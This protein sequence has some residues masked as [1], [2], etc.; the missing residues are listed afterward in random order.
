MLFH[1]RLQSATEA[2]RRALFC[3]PIIGRA[4]R[5]DIERS[6]YLR[7]LHE[8]YHHVRH[9]VPLLEACR[10][11]L[12]ERLRWMRPA[13]DAYV[14]EEA[15]HDE[16]ILADIAA[17]GGDPEATRGGR[18]G[19]ATELMV[20]YAYDTVTRGNPLGFLGMVHVL[21]GTSAALA[22]QAADVIQA[23]LGLADRA[24]V[25]LRS[26]GTLDQQHTDHFATLVDR[27][28]SED[29]RRAIEHAARMFYALYGGIFRELDARR[30]DDAAT[31]PVFA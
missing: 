7:F 11:A 17:A 22:L 16:W 4:L 6:E 24:M 10:D 15:G 29:D 27:L 23:R 8:A 5:G 21:E 19:R 26:H 1:E 28:A 3:A 25:Y 18:P 2:D 9:T 20:A 12:P 14:A 31:V 30:H 13:L